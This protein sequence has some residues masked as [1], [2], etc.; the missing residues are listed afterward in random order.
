MAAVTNPFEPAN[1]S[2]RSVCLDGSNRLMKS[3]A[4]WHFAQA[5]LAQTFNFLWTSGLYSS[6]LH[7]AFGDRGFYRS[8]VPLLKFYGAF[9]D[10]P[11]ILDRRCRSG[12]YDK[13]L[14][15]PEFTGKSPGV[16]D[17]NI[18]KDGHNARRNSRWEFRTCAE[19]S[20]LA[21]SCRLLPVMRALAAYRHG[22]IAWRGY[23]AAGAGPRYAWS[24]SQPVRIVLL[25]RTNVTTA[26]G[27]QRRIT[28]I[29]EVHAAL[30]RAF[31]GGRY[32]ASVERVNL[33]ALSPL[34]QVSLLLRTSV[35]LSYHGSGVGAGHFWL[36]PG[37]IVVEWTPPKVDYCIFATCGR[38]S[39]KGWIVG[40]TAYTRR[41]EV[42]VCFTR[43]L[44]T[45]CP[46]ALPPRTLHQPD[47]SSSSHSAHVHALPPHCI[48][49]RF[50]S[51]CHVRVSLCL[52]ACACMCMYAAGLQARWL[53]QQRFP[54][55][56]RPLQS[57][58]QR[59]ANRHCA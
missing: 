31:A 42:S 36:P 50:F 25:E 15:F 34:A 56:R 44:L 37:A 12:K 41:M 18:H 29:P 8:W 21:T 57:A 35:L 40:S 23:E 2:V 33:A 43:G 26:G 46:R 7:I 13:I 45:Q 22:G 53:Q 38:Q 19:N 47:G 28:N 3:N 17:W 11:P 55:R 20:S 27:P 9:F 24:A 14:Q 32:H 52:C 16:C 59:L 6:S 1:P 39:G 54:L 48:S 49:A 5:H 58:G 51:L 4:F 30:T 10:H